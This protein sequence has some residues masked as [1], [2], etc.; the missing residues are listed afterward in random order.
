MKRELAAAKSRNFIPLMSAS[1][2]AIV[3]L[4]VIGAVFRV[5]AARLNSTAGYEPLAPGTLAS[6]PIQIGDWI[7]RDIPLDER[8]REATDTDDLLSRQ[9]VR[10]NSGEVVH[11]YIAYGARARDLSPHR[12]E[13]CYPAAGWVAQ[14]TEMIDLASSDGRNVPAR[15][16]S[17]S[18][19]GF[20][21]GG[22]VV[23]NYFIVDGEYSP[24]ISLLRSKIW[25]G[26]HTVRYMS[27]IQI[28]CSE[29]AFR[30]REAAR[31]AAIAF[32]RDS[33]SAIHSVLQP[34]EAEAIPERATRAGG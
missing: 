26:T 31:S 25:T 32:A 9:Y 23:V 22:L 6:L 5:L 8:I 3:A 30:D 1:I 21:L 11:L 13:V 20:D 24:D 27:Q 16:L 19:G 10:R 15:S 34:A 4:L 29:T 7:G 17:F 2:A 18:H 12:P 28:A 14:G 33:A